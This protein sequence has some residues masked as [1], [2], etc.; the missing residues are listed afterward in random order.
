MTTQDI[1]RIFITASRESKTFGSIT[2]SYYSVVIMIPMTSQI[3]GAL[4]VYLT[5]C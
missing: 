1:L 4:I 2:V 3:T 5:V